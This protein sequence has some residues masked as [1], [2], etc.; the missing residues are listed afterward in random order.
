M[1]DR[2]AQILGSQDLDIEILEIP[3]WGTEV[4]VKACPVAS[5]RYND[6]VYARDKKGNLPVQAEIN[7]RRIVGAVIM[8]ALDPED[9]ER[10]FGWSDAEALR[11][12]NWNIITRIADLAFELALDDDLAGDTDEGKES[13]RND[14]TSD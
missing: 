11:E 12:K 13:S 5:P 4:A 6:F 2:K 1:G 8:S 7:Q 3:E 14:Q 10:L 9:H